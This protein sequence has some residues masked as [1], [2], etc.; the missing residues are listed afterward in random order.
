MI[1]RHWFAYV[2]SKLLV[3]KD[4]YKVLADLLHLFICI[5][6]CIV[7]KKLM[8]HLSINWSQYYVYGAFGSNKAIFIIL[9]FLNIKFFWGKFVQ[10]INISSWS[11]SQ[12]QHE[13]FNQYQP[14]FNQLSTLSRWDHF[15]GHIL[16]GNINHNYDIHKV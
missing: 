5:Y 3:T 11:E 2:V 9:N 15:S 7:L 16:Q 13:H 14:L 12:D 1:I 10:F 4:N 8:F 6:E